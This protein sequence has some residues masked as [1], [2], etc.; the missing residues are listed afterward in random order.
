MWKLNYIWPKNPL[1]TLFTYKNKPL[2]I[3]YIIIKFIAVIL[4]QDISLCT[5]EPTPHNHNIVT[6]F[7]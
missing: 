7:N 1:K 2:A 4:C 5:R 3:Y 6:K